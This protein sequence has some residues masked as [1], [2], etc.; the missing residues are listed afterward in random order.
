MIIVDWI[1]L[2]VLKRIYNK[3]IIVVTFGHLS[4]KPTPKLILQEQDLKSDAPAFL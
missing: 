1:K 2:N 4:H 3:S